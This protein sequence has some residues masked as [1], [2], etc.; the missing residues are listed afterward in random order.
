MK[1]VTPTELRAN[2]YRLLDEVLRTGIPLE[3]TKGNRRLRIVTTDP[4]DKLENLVDRP[5]ID[6]GAEI[7]CRSSEVRRV[8]HPEVQPDIEICPCRDAIRR[9]AMNDHGSISHTVIHTGQH[10]DEN[11][12]A[13]FF[14][15][16]DLPKPDLDLEVGSASHAVQTAAML[17]RLETA[18]ESD[19]PDAVLVFGGF[20]RT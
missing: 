18:F 9:R 3:I 14:K 5:E 6:I 13:T 7:G 11:M 1:T 19:S 16:L 17:T 10:Y 2:I 4:V 15:E 20:C 8:E 12:S